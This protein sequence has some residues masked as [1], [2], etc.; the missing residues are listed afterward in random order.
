MV[1]PRFIRHD[2][3]HSVGHFVEEVDECLAA[4]LR[5]LDDLD[6]AIRRIRQA[7]A[8]GGGE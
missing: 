2:L 4:L 3:P 8:A 1:D 5:R 7:I 6:D